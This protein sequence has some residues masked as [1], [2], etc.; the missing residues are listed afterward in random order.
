M[1]G[2]DKLGQVIEAE[3]SQLL[4]PPFS[5]V[6]KDQGLEQ[7]P[8]VYSRLWLGRQEYLNERLV[9]STSIHESA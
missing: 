2:E 6:A 9:V 4:L 3:A 1:S 5:Y 7:A 8:D